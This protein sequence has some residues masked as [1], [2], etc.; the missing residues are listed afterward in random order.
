M[1][2]IKANRRCPIG[3]NGLFFPCEPEDKCCFVIPLRIGVQIIAIYTILTCISPVLSMVNS[4]RVP[5]P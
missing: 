4:I 5:D 1:S 3:L 2:D